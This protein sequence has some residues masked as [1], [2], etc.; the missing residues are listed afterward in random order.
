MA[1]VV[2]DAS[3]AIALFDES[4]PHHARAVAA[5]ARTRE[6]RRVLPATAYA[7]CLVGPYRRGG[8]AAETI[9]RAVSEGAL[10]LAVVDRETARRAA[11]LRARHAS[12]PLPDAL[13]L[14]T[15]EVL[16]AEIVLTTDRAWP[17][18]SRRARLV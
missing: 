13:V 8:Q 3:A 10:E 12:L 18:I 7:E 16:D 2:L 5:I 4:D 15:G 1:V 11:Q 9:E 6:H 17:R 14:A